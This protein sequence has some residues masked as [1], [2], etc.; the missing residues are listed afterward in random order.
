MK[1]MLKRIVALC[2]VCLFS[3][4]S[5]ATS[6]YAAED[7]Q[8]E[9]E[10]HVF[11]YGDREIQYL[12]DEK[13]QPYY[14]SNG[15]RINLALPLEHLKVTDEALLAKLNSKMQN[16]MTRETNNYVPSNYHDLGVQPYE[17]TMSLSENYTDTDILKVHPTKGIIRIRTSEED[18]KF[19]KFGRKI[20]YILYYYS[21]DADFWY[22]YEVNEINCS[23]DTGSPFN[24]V[25][26]QIY[27][28]VY[29]DI[30]SDDLSSAKI[31]CWCTDV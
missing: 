4:M 19:L 14:E 9:K 29:Y 3:I 30:K 6:V 21:P 26:A 15:E 8:K 17:E 27:P 13:M 10:Y 16:E 18:R 23:N 7:C 28:Y 20:S 2:F 5:T 22:D 1:N 11:K 31:T 12:L 24:L 25:S